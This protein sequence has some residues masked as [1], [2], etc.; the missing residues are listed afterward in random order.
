LRQTLGPADRVLLFSNRYGSH[1]STKTLARAAV[2]VLLPGARAV[3]KLEGAPHEVTTLIRSFPET[4]SDLDGDR[5]FDEG[6][7]KRAVYDM[8]VAVTSQA[9][10]RAVVIGDVNVFSDPVLRQSN[11]NKQL[12]L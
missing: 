6:E 12:A 7:E 11:A 9:G 1:Q 3:E 8:A 10:A 5:A 2:P 4:W